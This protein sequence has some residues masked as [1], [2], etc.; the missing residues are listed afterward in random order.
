M[1]S[2][3]SLHGFS[4]IHAKSI[5]ANNHDKMDKII[6]GNNI[7]GLRQ[8]ADFNIDEINIVSDFAHK[9]ELKC[10]VA[11][12]KLMHNRDLE[13]LTA[14]LQ[15]LSERAIDGVIFSD[16]AVPHI[17]ELHNLKLESI[18]STETTITNSSF[19]R[20]ACENQITGIETAKEITLDEVNEIAR[21]KASEVMVQIH[22]HM[23]M[24]QSIRNMVDNFSEFQEVEMKRDPMYLYDS[25]RNRAYPLIQN[26]QGTH[27]LSSNNLAMIH[28]LDEL[29]LEQINSLRIDPLLYTPSEYNQIVNL[30][31]EALE[32]LK[33]DK[34]TYQLQARDF[35]KRLKQIKQDQKYGTGFFYKKT[36]Y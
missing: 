30:Y 12:N 7:F 14:Y 25:E 26:Q 16:L 23:Y 22:G 2:K 8:V 29:D 24:F 15:A 35:L 17:I 9:F 13:S 6:V 4:V 33:T 36:M 18:Y 28:K 32:L 20:F 11:V 19:S 1:N 5:I 21:E 31:I 34:S 27:M 3:L 10:Y